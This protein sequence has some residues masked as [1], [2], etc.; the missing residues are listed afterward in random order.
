MGKAI[1]N[2]DDDGEA[3]GATWYNRSPEKAR[4]NYFRITEGARFEL[5]WDLNNITRVLQFADPNA[6]FKLMNRANFGTFGGTRGSFSDI[7]TARMHHI[8]VWRLVF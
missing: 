6:A 5:R 4:A 7:G 2:A 3:R 1:N 8:L